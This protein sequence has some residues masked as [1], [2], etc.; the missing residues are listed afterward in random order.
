MFRALY[1]RFRQEKK[2]PLEET[3][4]V[5][6]EYNETLESEV[7]T[8]S[9]IRIGVFVLFL[10]LGGFL[11]WAALAPLDEGVPSQGVVSID[12][13][14]KVV[15]HQTG[16]IIKQVRV[17]EGQMVLAGEVLLTFDD[18][19]I[20]G[21][22]AEIRQHY[23]GLRANEGRLIAEQAGAA[24]IKFH[25][26]LIKLAD[27][28]LVQQQ[29]RNQEMLLAARRSGYEAELQGLEESVQGQLA[30]IQGLN[31]VLQSR[32]S[33]HEL[34]NV[35]LESI[36]D[37]VKEGYAPKNQQQE[38]ELKLIQTK[39]DIADA[40]SS[41]IKSQRTIAELRQ[42]ALARKGEYRKDVETQMAQVQSEV[43]ADAQKLLAAEEEFSRMQVRS[44]VNGQVVGLQF[45]TVGSVVQSGQKI[46][47][48]VPLNEG[49]LLEAKIAP[50][51]IDRVNTGQD[52]DVRFS[53]FSNSPLL[54]VEG[55]VESLSHDLLTEPNMNAELP[56][57]T[58]YLA[59]IS[60]TP[61]AMN[62][63]GDRILQPGMPVQIII[64]TGERTLLTYLLH[65]FIKRISASLKEE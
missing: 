25:E 16:G 39:G 29:M 64:K 55:R 61:S 63:L 18:S 17:K 21:R 54:A 34:I 7:D 65:P 58:Y 36:S 3:F 26:D 46:L 42:K 20:S 19:M 44:P 24:K 43:D 45:Q 49:L 50:H 23:I 27:D 30:Q 28:P 41:I 38:L 2:A 59:R 14:R 8:A 40:Q 33:Q 9:P 12:T 37:L 51:L 6:N 62:K 11:L 13:K 48:V 32:K 1:Q 22:L 4:S 52:A 47:D 56:G 31:G 53:S 10:G 15:Q 5:N 35:Q 60:L 57:A